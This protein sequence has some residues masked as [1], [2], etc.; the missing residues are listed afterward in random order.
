MIT[1][2]IPGFKTLAL[3][4]LVLDYNGTLALDG[5]LLPGVADAL[6]DLAPHLAIHVLTADT[7]GTAR[8]QLQGL[9]LELTILEP[10]EQARAKRQLVSQLGAT[11]VVAIGN[12]RND[13]L[14][15]AEAGLGIA[16]LQAEGA[17]TEAWQAAHLVC[18][19]ILDAL[20]LLRHPRR[21]VATL[22]G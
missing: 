19:T 5:R 7:F 17:A 6:A 2:D 1:I 20:D 10:E 16:V 22:R 15:L 11:T 18:P 12:G 4:H 14:M 21:L 13:R 9:A 8:A 3:Q